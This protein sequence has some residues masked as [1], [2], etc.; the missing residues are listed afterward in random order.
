MENFKK[1]VG[2]IQYEVSDLGRIRN[3][4]TGHIMKQSF[5]SSPYLIVKLRGDKP[6]TH[7]VHRLV[8]QAFIPNPEKKP[9]VNHRFGNKVDNRASKL[10][11]ATHSEN[12]QHMY[13]TGLKTYQPLHYKGKFG[14]D[15]NRSVKIE[16]VDEYGIVIA[17]FGG[18][19]EAH[20][21]TGLPT[22]S[23]SWACQHHGI[24]RKTRTFF[25]IVLK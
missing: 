11:W 8:A 3:A 16:Q 18:M 22:N 21:V 7:L 4:K 24:N 9:T 5:G 12:N 20:R 10:E 23:I 13:D 17:T 2:S 25:R 15:H 14:A 1:I 19:S 6:G